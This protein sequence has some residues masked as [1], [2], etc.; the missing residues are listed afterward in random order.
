MVPCGRLRRSCGSR[1]GRSWSRRTWPR[2]TQAAGSSGCS[3][4]RRETC[5]RRG[6]LGDVMPVRNSECGRFSHVDFCGFSMVLE[7][8]FDGLQISVCCP[9]LRK[10]RLGEL[11]LNCFSR[12]TDFTLYTELL[13]IL[14]LLRMKFY[15]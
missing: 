13:M 15:N 8:D 11:E 1:C 10:N 7:S 4:S 14:F 5:R 2:A 9:N 12:I 6:G 3:G